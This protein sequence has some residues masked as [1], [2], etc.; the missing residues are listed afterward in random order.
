METFAAMARL[1]AFARLKTDAGVV[2]AELDQL[3]HFPGGMANL[4]CPDCGEVGRL[5]RLPQEE[6]E[7]YW[8]GQ[9]SVRW[10]SRDEQPHVSAARPRTV[11]QDRESSAS[12]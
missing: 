9:C 6:I 4:T 12:R 1:P 3:L 10:P 7:F 5:V 8:C 11:T 2:S